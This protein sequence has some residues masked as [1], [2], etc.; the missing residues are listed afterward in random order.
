[1][2]PKAIAQRFA[3]DKLN[4]ERSHVKL[5]SVL[6]LVVEAL[7]AQGIPHIILKGQGVAQNYPN[8]TSRTCG[9]I[10]LYVRIENYAT[11]I[12]TLHPLSNNPEKKLEETIK[13]ASVFI[14]GIDIEIHKIAATNWN[15]ETT[16]VS[17][18]TYLQ[19]NI[20]QY[21]NSFT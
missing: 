1:M 21:F 19:R 17:L 3:I 16:M 14:Q 5:N 18:S 4:I 10:D 15:I 12:N 8:P 6:N 9:D 7:T 2:P 13:H 11:A 20:M